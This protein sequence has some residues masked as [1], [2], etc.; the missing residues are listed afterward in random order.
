MS[1]ALQSEKQVFEQELASGRELLDGELKDK[2]NKFGKQN[3]VVGEYGYQMIDDLLTSKKEVETDKLRIQKDKE[4]LNTLY[5]KLQKFKQELIKKRDLLLSLPDHCKACMNCKIAFSERDFASLETFEGSELSGDILLLSIPNEHLEKKHMKG[6]NDDSSSQRK[7]HDSVKIGGCMLNKRADSLKVVIENS[8]ETLDDML[9]E[10]KQLQKCDSEDLK[11]A[12]EESKLNLLNA[13][14]MGGR[15][16]QWELLCHAS[17]T[18]SKIDQCDRKTKPAN[19]GH[20]KRQ[21]TSEIILS[22]PGQ[23]RYN[24]RRSTMSVISLPIL[25]IKQTL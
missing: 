7:G 19:E 22:F 4:T 3:V 8:E 23:K 2:L 20:R 25:A 12:N 1:Q 10:I 9:E 17:D 15:A 13:D 6:Q 18:T 21:R 5:N 24:F 14:G 16:E 11:D